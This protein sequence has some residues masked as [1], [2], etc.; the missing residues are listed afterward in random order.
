MIIPL[1]DWTVFCKNRI[2]LRGSGA[3][4]RV[5]ITTPNAGTNG[6]DFFVDT[7]TLNIII[8]EPPSIVM[9]ATSGLVGLGYWWRRRK[10]ARASPSNGP[11]ALAGMVD[12]E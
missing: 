4:D 2:D 3:F 11:T 7:I 9:G 12:S 8:P 1:P 10:Q 6:W 5:F